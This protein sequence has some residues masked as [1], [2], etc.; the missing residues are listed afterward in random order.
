MPSQTL[1]GLGESAK[2]NGGDQADLRKEKSKYYCIFAG[3][4]DII[5]GEGGGMG[6]GAGSNFTD[7]YGF[8]IEGTRP[9]DESLL[10][11]L[12]EYL[13]LPKVNTK[14]PIILMKTMLKSWRCLRE[15]GS[16]KWKPVLHNIKNILAFPS[17]NML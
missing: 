8:R 16:K 6:Y 2:G 10:R 13:E 4:Y 14:P 12:K 9:A 17:G 1:R 5:L 7:K 15:N 3:G 11:A